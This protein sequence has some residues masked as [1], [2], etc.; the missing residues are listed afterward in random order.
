LVVICGLLAS[1]VVAH[2]GQNPEAKPARFRSGPV[3]ALPALGVG[4]GEVVLE[5]EVSEEGAVGAITVLRAAPSFSAP[6]AAAVKQWTFEPAEKLEQ[7]DDPEAPPALVP[8]ASSVLV[9]AVFRPPAVLGPARGEPSTTV[10]APTTAIPFPSVLAPPP[11]PP[12]A[13]DGGIVL[14]EARV[15]GRGMVVTAEKVDGAPG[16]DEAAL[17][18]VRAWTFLPARAPGVPAESYIYAILGFPTPIT[19]EVQ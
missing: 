10:G 5:V 8:A 9:V 18:T 1:V 13:R 3:P 4:G 17:G 15:D 2:E 11:W 6:V 12:L 14:V 16:F 19:G 7:P